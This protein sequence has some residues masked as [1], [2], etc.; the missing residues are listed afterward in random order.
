MLYLVSQ[1]GCD[2]LLLVDIVMSLQ[3]DTEMDKV[4]NQGMSL[5]SLGCGH[6][7]DRIEDCLPMKLVVV[8]KINYNFT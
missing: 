5:C 6:I 3:L 8:L 4:F 7:L 1:A 2:V